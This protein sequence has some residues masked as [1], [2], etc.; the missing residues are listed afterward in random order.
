MLRRLLADALIASGA[1]A[2]RGGRLAQACRRYRAAAVVAPRHAAAHLNL[3]AA[4]E[5]QG[6]AAAAERAYSALLAADPANPYGNYNLGRLR[7]A[8]GALEDADRLLRA[9]LQGKPDFADALIALANVQEARGE[10]AAAAANLESALAMRPDHGGAWYNFG[11]VL[12]KLDRYDEAEAALRRTLEL[13]PRFVPAWH[14]LGNMLRGTSRLGD[15]LDAFAAARR[16]APLR[17]DLE[18][19]E[20]L[21]LTLSDALSADEVFAR[22]RAFGERLEAAVPA[23][24]VTHSQV[25]APERR[26]R[27]GYVSSDF[28]RH[29][30]AW[31]ALPLFERHDRALVEVFCYSTGDK[32]DEVTGQVRAVADAWRE[33]RTMSD[34]ELAELIQR[35]AIDV[36]VD[37]TG[38]AGALRLGVFAHQPAPV[39]LS[40]LGYLHSTG[41][42]RIGYRLTDARADP[43]GPSD[44]LH[45]EKL[46]R[47]PHCLWCF[48]P[49]HGENH[50][51]APPCHRNGY[52]TFG[53]FNH[54]PKLSATVRRL[55][56]G[57]LLRL[58]Q[59]RLLLVGVPNGRAREDLLRDFGTA[60]VGAER[61]TILPRVSF[62]EYLEQFAAVDIALDTTPYGGGTTTFDTL[63]M[64]VPVL[65]LAG[66]RPASR[67]A[68]SILG[69]LGLEEWIAGSADE[70]LR[71]ALAHAAD[72][73]RIAALRASLRGRLQASPLMD[74]VRFTQDVEAV[75]RDLW[76]AWCAQR[77][78]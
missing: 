64:G 59:S 56:A 50:S 43:P 46:L 26:L 53:S 7:Y 16:L 48:R 20:L 4:L 13:E 74:E 51:L 54:A 69:A 66:D 70:Y 12:W 45:T 72:P 19:M 11:E 40:W 67:S 8:R 73:G 38:H 32:V 23:R 62:G 31:F 25:R 44:R 14:L 28:N 21:V 57:I 1:R 39:Q 71:L 9:A 29:P 10:Y 2:E 49:P 65:T 55:W 42:T 77:I 47:L 15:A 58:P 33:C 27:V 60:G 30:V 41:L 35:D 18:S 37:L 52:V 36:L 34:A 3:G 24:A 76:R 78:T 75:Y 61:L 68:A 6:D 5:A 17:F 22:H 63:W